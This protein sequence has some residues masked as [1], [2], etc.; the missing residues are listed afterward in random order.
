MLC[1]VE[2]VVQIPHDADSEKIK[3]LSAAEVERAKMDPVVGR[4]SLSYS[5][6]YSAFR[7]DGDL[8]RSFGLTMRTRLR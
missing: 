5:P 3:A 7:P 1:H 8:S 6:S 2:I 4:I